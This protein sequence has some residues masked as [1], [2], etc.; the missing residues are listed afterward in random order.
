MSRCTI[1][2]VAIMD[3]ISAAVAQ[4]LMPFI[5][6]SDPLG[7]VVDKQISL[8]RRKEKRFTLLPSA[9][10]APRFLHIDH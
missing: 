3:D 9:W 1:G 10:L 7:T 8:V 6:P 4:T 5:F 2:I